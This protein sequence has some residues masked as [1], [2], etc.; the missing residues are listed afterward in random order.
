MTRQFSYI[1]LPLD[2]ISK[3]CIYTFI[4]L[5][6]IHKISIL[7]Q[8]VVFESKATTNIKLIVCQGKKDIDSHENV[9][10][11]NIPYNYGQN[12]QESII[13]QDQ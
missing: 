1:R 13:L 6:I 9:E 11:A 4:F 5:R 10:H 3:L 7:L 12:K 2:V 8:N